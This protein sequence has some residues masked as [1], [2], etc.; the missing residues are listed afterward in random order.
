MADDVNDS[1]ILNLSGLVVALCLNM[2]LLYSVY[3]VMHF[4]LPE[5]NHD[6]VVFLLGFLTAQ[7]GSIVNFYYGSSSNARKQ[8]STASNLAQTVTALTSS[9]QTNGHKEPT[10]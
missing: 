6:N 5:R 7:V 4:D 3:M 8:A 1:N 2:A 10:P 9:S